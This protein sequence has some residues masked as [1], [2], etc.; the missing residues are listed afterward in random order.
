MQLESKPTKMPIT[1]ELAFNIL[2]CSIKCRVSPGGP[3]VQALPSQCRDAGLI[4]G[5]GIKPQ[6]PCGKEKNKGRSGQEMQGE[7]GVK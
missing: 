3:A 4:P 5:Q 7:G 1:T 2:M 6:V